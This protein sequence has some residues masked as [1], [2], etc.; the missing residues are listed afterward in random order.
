ME[1]SNYPRLGPDSFR[2][3][4]DQDVIGKSA[5]LLEGARFTRWDGHDA[6]TDPQ[7]A[8]ASERVWFYEGELD[9]AASQAQSAARYAS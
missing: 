7:K 8:P 5:L 9:E 2:Y 1:I 6:F 4:Q 3:T